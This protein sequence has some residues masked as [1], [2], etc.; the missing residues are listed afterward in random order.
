[1]SRNLACAALCAALG[2][3]PLAAAACSSAPEVD[4]EPSRGPYDHLPPLERVLVGEAREDLMTGDLEGAFA[5]LE[6]LAARRAENVPLAVMLQE[7]ELGR[8]GE[9]G[10]E[11]VAEEARDRA[12]AF[13][14]PVTLLLAARVEADPDRARA[15]IERALRIDV[16][17]AWA[18]YA[19]AHLE[20]REGHWVEAQTRLARALEI[21][22]GHLPGRR[23]EA[24]FLARDGK[25]TQAVDALER[26]LLLTENDPLVDPGDRFLAGLDLAQ[27][28]LL[29]GETG[30]ART[31]ALFLTN[32]PEGGA[33]TRLAIL[34]AVEQARGDP[35]RALRAAVQAEEADPDDPL[36]VL[37]QALLYDAWLGDP[38]AARAQ[39][40]R[41]IEI[42]RE[43]G[44][45][46]GLLQSMRAR[47]ELER[48][49][50]A[51]R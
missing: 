3:L 26:W 37:Q 15:L 42:A 47:V 35:E 6:P 31:L 36:P 11:A 43:Q 29:E 7:V 21:D 40:E 30:R 14:T 27:L 24:A 25:N 19:L 41:L 51:P 1:M 28:H 4:Y 45:L 38:E 16:E 18:H 8:A 48:S 17:C 10:R 50:A 39:W 32:E 5:I 49:V 2:V 12:E 20:A 23:L 9:A 44:D 22:P 13:P 34:A 46:G 33:A